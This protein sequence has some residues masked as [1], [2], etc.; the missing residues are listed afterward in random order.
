MTA[1][2]A[3]RRKAENR[4]AIGDFKSIDG[5]TRIRAG[6]TTIFRT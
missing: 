2:G 5:E 6:D 3:R 1:L 4:D